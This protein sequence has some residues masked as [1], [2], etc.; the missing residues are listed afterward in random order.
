[1]IDL[2]DV[3]GTFWEHINTKYD[4][5]NEMKLGAKFELSFQIRA[6]KPRL[7]AHASRRQ[8]GG[9]ASIMKPKPKTKKDRITWIGGKRDQNIQI[10]LRVRFHSLNYIHSLHCDVP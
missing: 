4:D 1:M 5:D 6:R 2:K 8:L 3:K 10:G 9:L 7:Q